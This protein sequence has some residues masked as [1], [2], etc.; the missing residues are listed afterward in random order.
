MI[1]ILD[2]FFLHLFTWFYFTDPLEEDTE[3]IKDSEDVYVWNKELVMAPAV[4]LQPD[5]NFYIVRSNG[6][7][8]YGRFDRRV[9]LKKR[10]SSK[11]D[12]CARILRHRPALVAVTEQPTDVDN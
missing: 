7:V 6:S 10:V 12:S 5:D 4:T 8:R 3:P 9:M 2:F 1:F 11:F